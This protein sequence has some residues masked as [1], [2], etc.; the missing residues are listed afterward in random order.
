MLNHPTIDQV[1][2]A[3]AEPS[4]RAIIERL[5][6][7][8]ASV[9]DL[10]RPLELT[11]AAVVQHVQNLEHSGLI[12]TRKV[13]RVRTCDIELEALRV[14]D[15]WIAQRRTLWVRRLDRLGQVLATEPPEQPQKKKPSS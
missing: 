12:R 4:R 6:L 15:R 9:S 7:G 10:A 14:A 8:P 1:F 5:S 3:L 11:L 2:H 13:G